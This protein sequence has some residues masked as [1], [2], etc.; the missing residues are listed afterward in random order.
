MKAL[1]FLAL[2][3]IA[4]SALVFAAA[5]PVRPVASLS[6]ILPVER[7]GMTTVETVDAPVLVSETVVVAPKVAKT[8]RKTATFAKRDWHTMDQ[9]PVS[10]L[11][12]D[13]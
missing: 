6:E 11:V 1:G 9:G 13:L 8:A 10:R 7:H 5:S 2:G 3:S 4:V 12:R